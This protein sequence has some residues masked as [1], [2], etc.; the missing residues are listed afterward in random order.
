MHFELA[1]ETIRALN[2]APFSPN[3][4][5]AADHYIREMGYD[6]VLRHG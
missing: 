1:D 2:D 5:I 4:L 6:T 3:L